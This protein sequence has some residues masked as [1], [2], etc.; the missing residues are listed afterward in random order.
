MPWSSLAC[1]RLPYALL[2]RC[3]FQPG[4]TT[5]ILTVCASLD[6]LGP[7]HTQPTHQPTGAT[8]LP[9]R[10]TPIPV[11]NSPVETAVQKGNPEVPLLVPPLA[12]GLQCASR[13]SGPVWHGLTQSQHLPVDATAWLSLTQLQSQ[14]FPAGVSALPRPTHTQPSCE[15]TGIE[16]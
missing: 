12:Q 9:N 10:P 4:Q 15:L 14:L 11:L 2:S 7:C 13:C 8:A 3:C 5:R 1:H 6:K 16:A